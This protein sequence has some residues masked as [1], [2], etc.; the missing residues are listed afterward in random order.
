MI[1][2]FCY[3]FSAIAQ[4]TSGDSTRN[5]IDLI[6]DT[7]APLQIETLFLKAHNNTL[8]THKIFEDII[9]RKP[10]SL[11]ILGDVVSL[12]YKESKWTEIDRFLS[13]ARKNS[14][15]VSALLGNHDVMYS[16]KQ[17][18]TNFLKR[19]PDQVN[20]GFYKVYDSI[21]FLMLNANFTKLS[22]AQKETQYVFY[23]NSLE[24]LDIDKAIKFIVVSCH[25]APYS[26]SKIVGSNK[27]VQ[28]QF[29]PAF[30]TSKKTKLF[31]TGHAHAFEHFKINGKD[32]LTIGG[33]GGL[34]QPL[35][36]GKD[37]IPS[38][39]FGYDP[40]FHYLL[41]R[42]NNNQLTLISRVLKSDFSGFDNKY[43]F[44]VD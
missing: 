14:I 34:H 8:A 25:Q 5:E 18:E 19:F 21:A 41:L 16:S 6:S 11:L 44:V 15:P 39:S 40:E 22:P 26:N 42:R 7:Q 28:K 29:L 38:L 13:I 3:F 23:L 20:T 37:R 30:F 33:G 35:N 10:L 1:G 36:N 4:H 32:F 17:G 43:R 9:K 24:K 31:I 12:G 27:E 2:S